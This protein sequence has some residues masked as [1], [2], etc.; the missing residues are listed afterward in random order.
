[1]LLMAR[2]TMR[3]RRKPKHW[4]IS[5]DS[6]APVNEALQ[7]ALGDPDFFEPELL[8]QGKVEP[9]EGAVREAAVSERDGTEG[10]SSCV[11]WKCYICG[12]DQCV[13][14]YSHPPLLTTSITYSSPNETEKTLF[15]QNNTIY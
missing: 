5:G 11:D 1:M 14:M 7:R 15:T 9:T 3:T 4:W 12:V 8:K 10:G 13:H 6:M 2:E